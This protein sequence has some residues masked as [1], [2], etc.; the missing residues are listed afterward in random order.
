MTITKRTLFPFLL[1]FF[2]ILTYLSSDMYLP[3]L[4]SVMR[5]LNISQ[6]AVQLTLSMWFLGAI[7]VQLILGP[8][9]DRYG[10]KAVLC[11]GGVLFVLSTLACALAPNLNM[12]LI[13][14]FIQGS[15]ICFMAV[16]GYASIHEMF[17]QKQAIRII[18]FMGSIS[19][20]APAAGPLIGSIILEVASWRWIFGLILVASVFSVGLL[21]AFMPETL[22]DETRHPINAKK[23]L[24][25]YSQILRNKRFMITGIIFGLLFCGFI[26][27]IVAGPLLVIERFEQSPMVFGWLQALIFACY[28][29]GNYLVKQFIETKPPQ[30]LIRIGLHICFWSTLV[31]TGLSLY[32]SADLFP[33]VL[34][35]MFYSFGS[36]L[37]FAPLNRLTIESA[38]EP[39]GSRMAVFSMT[40]SSFATIG[41]V[42]IGVVYNGSTFFVAIVVL[43]VIALALIINGLM[44]RYLS[45]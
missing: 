16:P 9:A 28:I 31:F 14:R 40:M 30:L 1:V 8:L 45:S 21:M 33:I 35:Y 7:S 18:A 11:F 24:S 17:D 6:H 27:W 39:M 43:V 20:L 2:E 23:V 41:S 12:L 44:N 26:T 42:A 25:V 3:A 15:G 29:F 22:T 5:D 36:G 37:A 34:L 19:V 10:R 4:P 32:Y 38:N 13:A